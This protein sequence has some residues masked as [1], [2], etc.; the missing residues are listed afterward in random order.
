MR[1]VL[2]VWLSFIHMFGGQNL[3][4]EAP[5]FSGEDIRPKMGGSPEVIDLRERRR[6]AAV[7]GMRHRPYRQR[8]RR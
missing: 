5:D 2:W 6:E 1:L 4:R 7:M 8:G 3:K